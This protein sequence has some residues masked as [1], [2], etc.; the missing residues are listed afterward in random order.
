M[1]NQQALKLLKILQAAY[2]RQELP[3]DSVVLYTK[4]LLPLDYQEMER[5]V[6][7]HIQ[8]QKWFPTVSELYRGDC[9][10]E[11]FPRRDIEQQPA[12]GHRGTW[13]FLEEDA[14]D[15]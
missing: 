12:L 8:T 1:N 3:Q 5:T 9:Y 6:M 13:S 10:Q 2:P 15:D 11:M 4:M 7:R 14:N